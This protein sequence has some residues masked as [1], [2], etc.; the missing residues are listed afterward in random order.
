MKFWLNILLLWTLFAGSAW[1]TRYS[2]PQQPKTVNI[3][4]DCHR[5]DYDYI[6]SEITWVNYVIDPKNADVYVMIS[7]SERE[8]AAGN[9]RFRS[10]D[11]KSGPLKATR[12]GL[13]RS[14]MIRV[15]WS[16]ESW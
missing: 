9:T 11:K 3:Y 6:R 15:K 10:S 5:C 2:L 7:R 8:A 14:G 13:R 16:A 4:I 1:A 12:C